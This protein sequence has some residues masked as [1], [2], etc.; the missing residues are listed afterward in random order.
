[1][2]SRGNMKNYISYESI[3]S[4]RH[5][6]KRRI[7]KGICIKE[8]KD[9]ESHD[10]CKGFG[11]KCCNRYCCHEDYFKQIMNLECFKDEGCQ[12]SMKIISPSVE[13][14]FLFLII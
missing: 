1:M 3:I 4:F 5:P 7:G 8:T 14:I 13:L 12:V 6:D 2:S 10:Q 11:G 9:C